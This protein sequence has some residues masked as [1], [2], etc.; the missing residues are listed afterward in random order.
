MADSQIT[1]FYSWQSDLPGSDTR[2][3]IQ[4]SI[5]DAVR[6]LRDTVDIEADRDTKGKFGSPDIVQTIF[7]KIDD[8]D[9]FIADVSAVC[10]YETIDKDG[11]KKIKY[12]PNPN[13][14][15][16]L[17]Y[18]THVV[19]WDRVICVLNSDYGAPENM[20]FDIASRRLT[21]FSLK[22]G[23]SKGE[24]KRY[25]KSVIQDTVENVLEKGKRVKA[26]FSDLRLGCFVDGVVSNLLQPIEVSSSVSFVKHKTQILDE[27][28]KL[29]EQIRSNKIIEP[30]ELKSKEET[31]DE[32]KERTSDATP[33]IRSDG[34]IL[35]PFAGPFKLNPF[36]LQKV[37]INDEDR[38]SI[39]NLCKEYLAIDISEDSEFFNIGNLEK[40]LD[41]M[42]SY[43][44]EGTKEEEDKYDSIMMLEYNL[45]HV[46]MMDLYVTTFNGMLF[47][48]LAIENVSK[49]YDEEVNV[50]IK[51]KKDVAEAIVPS[52]ELINPNLQ[53][54]EGLIYEDD[55]IK[56]L[57]K[58]PDSADI[59]Y[60]ADM[61]YTLADSLAESQAVVRAQFCG[62][63]INGNSR[64]NS[65]DYGKEITKYIA[66]P[67][68][69]S[70]DIE[71]EFS[72]RSLR[73]KE[74]KWLG[75]ALLLNPLTD[76]FNIEYFIKS[77]HSDGDLSGIVTYAK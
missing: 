9:I 62:A 28:L 27:S 4:D 6:L 37:Y 31:N 60:D 54:L 18:A 23:K 48:P 16:E 30:S 69:K 68:V 58:M 13:V 53:E 41:F 73:A 12:M 17:G 70:N 5:K 59:S 47:I 64:Y 42:S 67:R 56:E 36:K 63:R 32:N 29:V 7:S 77:K 24:I 57:L 61:S 10:Q 20:P 66:M 44:Y 21:T 45:H 43:S 71:F 40:K 39:I 34:S 74:M 75:P 55:I 1:I 15:L 38:D 19:G 33:I 76:S 46:H 2:N 50:Q 72:I 22:D 35:T 25:I 8:C 52:K 3:I 65:D 11:N 51:I 49:V 26:G 14:M